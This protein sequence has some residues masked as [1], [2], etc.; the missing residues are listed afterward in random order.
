MRWAPVL[1]WDVYMM[2]ADTSK[3]L[4]LLLSLSMRSQVHDIAK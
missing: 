4:R 2:G 3:C 1:Y